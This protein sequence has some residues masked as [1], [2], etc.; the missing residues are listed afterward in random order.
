MVCSKTCQVHSVL[1]FS[2]PASEWLTH[3]HRIPF[4]PYSLHLG[5]RM[6][7][8]S[9][10]AT[11]ANPW[12]L[13][14]TAANLNVASLEHAIPG[15]R[16]RCKNG[17][18]AILALRL[19]ARPPAQENHTRAAKMKHLLRQTLERRCQLHSVTN[20]PAILALLSTK[21]VEITIPIKDSLD[22]VEQQPK[23]LYNTLLVSKARWHA[24]NPRRPRAE[25]CNEFALR[26]ETTR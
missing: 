11:T 15:Q 4:R 6:E 18:R 12:A 2:R 9:F 22:L 3:C 1:P 5:V 21:S 16:L 13:T 24:I 14:S 20:H 7:R 25:A 26:A 8:A 10:E 19:I 23:E 17:L